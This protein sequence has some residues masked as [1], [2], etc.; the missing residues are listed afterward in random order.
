M[1][2]MFSEKQIKDMIPPVNGKYK[3]R[4]NLNLC[5]ED[6]SFVRYFV[7]GIQY[8]NY[9]PPKVATASKWREWLGSISN[10]D[11][12]KMSLLTIYYDGSGDTPILSAYI[13]DQYYSEIAEIYNYTYSLVKEDGTIEFFEGES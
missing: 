4:I 11:N 3:Y 7:S 2:K 10:D 12:E 8:T 13:L 1:R 5:Y 6:A 9:E